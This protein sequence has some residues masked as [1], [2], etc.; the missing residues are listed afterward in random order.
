MQK[1]ILMLDLTSYCMIFTRDSITVARICHCPSVHPSVRL[2]VCHTVDQ[3]K[4][5]EVKIMQFSTVEEP[6]PSSFC[7]LFYPEIL[8]GSP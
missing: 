2:S 6:H 1:C 3:S 5:V 8:K 7:R 4:P